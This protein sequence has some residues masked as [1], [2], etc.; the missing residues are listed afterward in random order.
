MIIS[1]AYTNMVENN[2][3]LLQGSPLSAYL[4]IIYA[5]HVM[6][7]YARILSRGSRKHKSYKNEESGRNRVKYLL[8]EQ[9]PEYIKLANNE[10]D[11]IRQVKTTCYSQMMQPLI[12]TILEI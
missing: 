7:R 8:G 1:D 2:I 12:T 5:D 6:G 9:N 3:G 11:T 4:L 10:N